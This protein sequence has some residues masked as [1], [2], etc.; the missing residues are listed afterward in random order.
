MAPRLVRAAAA[1]GP[2]VDPR[3]GPLRLLGVRSAPARPPST[4]GTAP[5][6]KLAAEADTRPCWRLPRPG[7]PGR[8]DAARPSAARLRRQAR[9]LLGQVRVASYR[10]VRIEPSAMAF[11]R[12][13]AAPCPV[14]AG[15][16]GPGGARGYR[17]SCRGG[18]QDPSRLAPPALTAASFCSSSSVSAIEAAATF[19]WRCPMLVEPGS[20]TIRCSCRRCWWWTQA[21][22]TCPGVASRRAAGSARAARRRGRRRPTVA[23]VPAASA[24]RA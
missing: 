21:S 8:G 10:S 22:A 3:S 24:R 11:T 16:V 4:G 19:V 14:V 17:G 12:M 18:A 23:R 2:H 5:M 20:G 1:I 9:T 15:P 13:P 7:R 6:M